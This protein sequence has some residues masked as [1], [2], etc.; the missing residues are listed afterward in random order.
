MKNPISSAVC[1]I[2][3]KK[4]KTLLPYIKEQVAKKIKYKKTIPDKLAITGPDEAGVLG[5]MVV[6]VVHAVDVAVQKVIATL[7]STERGEH[8]FIHRLG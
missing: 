6:Q 5:W 4:Q 7:A 1:E 8:T 2:L 3:T